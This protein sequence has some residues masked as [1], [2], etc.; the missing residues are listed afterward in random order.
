MTKEKNTLS[1]P[2]K[3]IIAVVSVIAVLAVGFF[4]G[5]AVIYSIPAAKDCGFSEIYTADEI[6]AA[7][8]TVE[9]QFSDFE[10]CKLFAL[11]YAGDAASLKENGYN[12]SYDQAIVIDS[13][14]LSPLRSS[15]AWN[16]HKIYTWKFI[17][18]REAGGEWQLLDWGYC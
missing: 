6:L 5:L 3:A 14:F 15:G 16:S 10:G 1:K 12:N 13:V 18:M 17:L 9:D 2:K 11:K 4:A 8:D 7:I